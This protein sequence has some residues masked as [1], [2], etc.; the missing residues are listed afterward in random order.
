VFAGVAVVST[1]AGR[2]LQIVRNSAMQQQ[3]NH[4]SIPQF[5]ESDIFISHLVINAGTVYTLY[6][7]TSGFFLSCKML[8]K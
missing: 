5:I 8:E 7:Y 1:T 3:L 2:D 4:S 6:V